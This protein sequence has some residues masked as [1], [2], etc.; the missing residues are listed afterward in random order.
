MFLLGLGAFF[1]E[2]VCNYYF[3][4]ADVKIFIN[5]LVRRS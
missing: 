1:V 5:P 2:L 3:I 4:W